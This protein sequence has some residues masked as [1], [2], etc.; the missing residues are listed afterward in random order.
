LVIFLGLVSATTLRAQNRVPRNWNAEKIKGT[1][2][3]LYPP[4]KG[5][6]FLNDKYLSGEI[7]LAD[8]FKIDNLKLRYSSYRD[9]LIYFNPEISAQI[10]IDKATLRGFTIMDGAGAKRIFSLQYY[11]GYSP[12]L[13][14]F[15]VLSDGKIKLLAF[16]KVV[17]ELCVPY[18][19]IAGRLNNVDYQEAYSYYFYHPEKG[20]ELI[21]PNKKSLLSKFNQPDQKQIKTILRKSGIKIAGEE[22]FVKAWSVIVEKGIEPICQFEK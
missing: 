6:P 2:F 12:G 9:E 14:F 10:V 20:Y 5:Q 21:R 22:S 3:I 7:E 4:A 18:N 16:R 13:H 8:G 11:G 17:L 19:D 15:E 1:R